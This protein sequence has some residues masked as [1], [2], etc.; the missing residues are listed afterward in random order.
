M[1]GGGEPAAGWR[2]RGR[3]RLGARQ[4]RG[5]AHQHGA[6]R[7]VPRP[8]QPAH[9]RVPAGLRH[10]RQLPGAGQRVRAR[11]DEHQPALQRRG[12]SLQSLPHRP[13]GLRR[14]HVL[15]HCRAGLSHRLPA[16]AAPRSV[17]DGIVCCLLYPAPKRLRAAFRSAT[18]GEDSWEVDRTELAM[19]QKLG[20]GQY[21]DVYQ[22]V[23]KR[24]GA[25]GCPTVAVKTIK[26]DMAMK[27]NEFL[28]EAQMMKRMEHQNLVQ[29][30]GV[31]T[32]EP[33]FYI[34]TEY[35]AH[36]SLLEFLRT[37]RLELPPY[38]LLYMATQ[39]A[40]GM[41]YL[42]QH[43][44]VHRDLAARNCL[45]GEGYVVKVADFGLT[46]LLDRDSPYVAHQGA[47]F[48]IK[49]TAPEGL[50]YNQFDT[51]SDVWSF[52][53]LLWEIAT[54]GCSPYPKVELTE[55]YQLLESGYRM[56]KPPVCP[57]SVYQL[58]LRCWRWEPDQRPAFAELYASLK[59]IRDALVEDVPPSPADTLPEMS[60]ASGSAPVPLRP[61]PRTVRSQSM[62][63]VQQQQQPQQRT[64]IGITSTTEAAAACRRPKV[65]RRRLR[66]LQPPCPK[67]APAPLLL[68][69]VGRLRRRRGA[70]RRS[71]RPRSS[72]PLTQ[73]L[74]CPEGSASRRPSTSSSRSSSLQSCHRL[75]WPDL[76]LV[77]A[78]TAAPAAPV[79]LC[80]CGEGVPPSW[81]R[82][83]FRWPPRRRAAAAS[84]R[85]RRLRQ[86]ELRP[87]CR[88][89]LR[90]RC[91]SPSRIASSSSCRLRFT[92][93]QPAPRHPSCRPRRLPSASPP[94]PLHLPLRLRLRRPCRLPR[95]SATTTK[96]PRARRPAHPPAPRP[97]PRRLSPSLRVCR[98]SRSHLQQRQRKL[99][100]RLQQRSGCAG[101]RSNCRISSSSSRSASPSPRSSS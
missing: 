70:P 29:L 1:D 53:V 31:C 92:S 7:L 58:M 46:R 44:F 64:V 12:L 6:V 87:C 88:L 74:I 56:D 97:A 3:P 39:I 27:V 49:W 80:P 78:A 101:G 24:G 90:Q 83:R 89:R 72:S 40:N 67:P 65:R 52:G 34:I 61:P 57:D 71:R 25:A 11:P 73:A 26:E 22:A 19:K 48:P 32:T 84:L 76:C 21:G 2:R 35:M 86:I 59:A 79:T 13:G 38:T 100:V 66:L 47:K 68:S 4:L 69:Q 42:E 37:H 9:C 41:A 17:P 51:R 30:L 81:H 33:P 5:A 20:A 96:N 75:R 85:G 43:C 50:A 36:G 10:Q 91:S 99:R 55:V 94:P 28:A 23:W 82:R 14:R 54:Y 18:S 77:T 16:G 93:A 8:D 45:V 62:E 98:R 15:Y 60:P 63:Q 95:T